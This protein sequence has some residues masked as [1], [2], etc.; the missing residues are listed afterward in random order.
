MDMGI[1]NTSWL[2]IELQLCVVTIW[3]VVHIAP[4]SICNT[5][6]SN[7]EHRKL[8]LVLQEAVDC[9]LLIFCQACRRSAPI[10]LQNSSCVL[11][12]QLSGPLCDS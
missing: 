3:A 4:V 9:Q 12:F 2:G 10:L 1:G 5:L 11:G 6:K 7:I 8:N